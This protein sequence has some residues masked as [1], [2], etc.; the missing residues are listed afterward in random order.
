MIVWAVGFDYCVDISLRE[1]SMVG[2]TSWEYYRRVPVM[3]WTCCVPTGSKVVRYGSVREYWTL[4][5]YAGEV[6]SCGAC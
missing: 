4:E 6:K 5:Q 2:Y 3:D 1:G